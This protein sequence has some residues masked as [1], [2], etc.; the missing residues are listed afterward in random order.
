MDGHVNSDKAD[1][2]VSLGP[3]GSRSDVKTESEVHEIYWGKYLW[4][5]KA[6]GNR[7]GQGKPL[8]QKTCKEEEEK[9]L[10]QKSLRLQHRC[11]KVSAR[12]MANPQQVLPI[13]RPGIG[14]KWPSSRITLSSIIGWQH[15]GEGTD[16]VGMC[17]NPKSVAVHSVTK[18]TTF[19]KEGLNRTTLA[20]LS[21]EE[22]MWPRT[23][24]NVLMIKI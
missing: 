23:K 11:R 1:F 4:K 8:R 5:I 18:H 13:R 20:A 17:H 10:S 9:N 21:S 12:L 7:A 15:P 3:E 14:Q 24:I 16:T 19:W 6:R 2:C 22:G